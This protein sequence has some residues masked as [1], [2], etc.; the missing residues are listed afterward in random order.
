MSYVDTEKLSAIM[1]RKGLDLANRKVLHASFEKTLQANDLK[2]P[3]NCGGF[4]RIRHFQRDYGESWPENPLP[5]DP[6]LHWL[7]APPANILRVQLFQSAVCTWRCWYC[8]VDSEV[9]SGH[10][11]YTA[12]KSPD[13]L[14]DSY[15]LEANRPQVIVLSGGQPDLIPEWTLWFADAMH[16]R[17][18]H[19]TTYLWTDDNLS[20]DYLWKYLAPEEIDRLSRYTN[21]GRVGCFKGFDESSFSFNTRAAPQEFARQFELMKRLVAQG[22]D[23][24]GYATFT[25]DR[26][27]HIQSKV[28]GFVDKLQEVHPLF[29][30]RTV[31]LKIQRWTPTGRRMGSEQEKA[32]LLQMDVAAAWMDE[33]TDRF[34]F[35]QRSAPIYSHQIR[36]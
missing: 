34:T 24:Y 19:T 23:V 20:N 29:P 5:I 25:T 9:L 6:A 11:L 21:Y 26:H 4:G 13:E 30:L 16:H 10:P 3:P 28:R 33:L 1:R 7:G 8:F 15:Q 31:P 35:D 17:G 18:L 2:E 22:F 36:N 27:D 14:L 32:L 12:F